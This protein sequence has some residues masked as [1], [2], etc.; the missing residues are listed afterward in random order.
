M[1]DYGELRKRQGFS[2][3]SVSTDSG[4]LGTVLDGANVNGSDVLRDATGQFYSY[5]PQ[6]AKLLLQGNEFR[7]PIPVLKG[8]IESIDGIHS[9]SAINCGT[10]LF[11]WGVSDPGS[12][13]NRI[14][15]QINNATSGNLVAG[16]GVLG[17]S[18][19]L[20]AQ[21][22]YDGSGSIWMFYHDG[23][24]IKSIKLSA[25]SGSTLA[26]PTTY[27]TASGGRA[28]SGLHAERDAT[29][30]NIIVVWQEFLGTSIAHGH[31]L[32]DTATGAPKGS[33]AAVLTAVVVTGTN[34]NT[35]CGIRI[36]KYSGANGKFYYAFWRASDAASPRLDLMLIQVTISSLAI[37]T[38]TNLR[39][40]TTGMT[41][42]AEIRGVCSG[43]VAANG[44]RVVL[45]QYILNNTST[46][47]TENYLVSK[48]T[49]D[50]ATA[51]TA[52]FAR[53]SWLASDPAQLTGDSSLEWYV[54]TG[55]EDGLSGFQRVLHLRKSDGD[56]QSQ[57][58]SLGRAPPVFQ[59]DRPPLQ[60]STSAQLGQHVC[61]VADFESPVTG[62][63]VTGVGVG[64]D[65]VTSYKPNVL[66]WD[67]TV[68]LG[69]PIPY[70]GGVVFPGGVPCFVGPN[71]YLQPLTPLLSP[72]YL[73][74]AAGGGGAVGT[75]QVAVVYRYVH[76]DGTITRSAPIE[77]SI[78]S[79]TDTA[80]ITFPTLRHHIGAFSGAFAKWQA[81]IYCSTVGSTI[82][83][84]QYVVE[85][86]VFGG[87]SIAS[88]TPFYNAATAAT[89][90][91]ITSGVTLYTAGGAPSN[92]PA[93]P[94]RWIN[95]WRDRLILGGTEVDGEIWVTQEFEEQ[96]GPTFN[97][98][99]LRYFWTEGEGPITAGEVIS[100]DYFSMFKRNR[101]GI[102]S[103]PGPDGRGLNGSYI[104]Q[105]LQGE[106]GTTNP[107]SVFHGPDGT[108]FQDSS[109]GRI[110]TVTASGQVVENMQ[111]ADDSRT[112]TVLCSAYLEG[113]STIGNAGMMIY[114]LTGGVYLVQDVRWPLPGA[115]GQ[116][117]R[118]WSKWNSNASALSTP[119]TILVASDGL[120][121]WEAGGPLRKFK[122]SDFTDDGGG[123]N[124]S[125]LQKIKTGKMSPFSA[126]GE[127]M[128]DQIIIQAH[129]QG[130]HTL[131]ITV[132]PDGGTP[133]VHTH[134]ASSPGVW[135]VEPSGCLNVCEVEIQIEETS[136]TTEGFILEA[137]TMMAKPNKYVRL[138]STTQKV[139]PS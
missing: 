112:S 117:T 13:V 16:Y 48:T 83:T 107:T 138:L 51:T 132:T 18:G 71:D 115:G 43:Y 116:P 135:V 15:Y 36:L 46:E 79:A 100:W 33:P 122:T 6:Q 114:G 32:L 28:I 44:D 130:A 95:S 78:A 22:V 9:T 128:I 61:S 120:H 54:M 89:T 65:N 59:N 49:W 97:A 56:I 31:S 119:G 11:L 37:D 75:V 93:P 126:N 17:I 1:P 60:S 131:R 10:N 127:G 91:I 105:T 41:N 68:T 133:S 42:D 57:V 58:L 4:I 50:G 72:S 23:T 76:A 19:V 39:A 53:G 118:Q 30:G 66:T 98:A 104:P 73:T 77:A 88:L 139:A 137:I 27:V 70:K 35:A 64:T 85:G 108:Y 47:R 129:Y 136:S 102:L 26:G 94:C 86:T 12:G 21:A 2:R 121:I 38:T 99:R 124:G 20:Q 24:T 5:D 84:L 101:V 7:S 113:D 52:D 80:T 45:N 125:Y 63:F 123:G 92:S 3:T 134:S 55:F 90:G 96:T 110:C 14:V 74:T 111:G 29:S 103:G 8:G 87:D 34:V 69:K 81:E 25:A 82:P 106:R 109:T 62:K 40:I 67:F